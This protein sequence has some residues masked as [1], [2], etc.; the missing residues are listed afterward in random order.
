MP[1]AFPS[2][3]HSSAKASP[4]EPYRYVILLVGFVTL[5]GANGVS[6]SCQVFYAALL[7]VFDWSHAGGA[8]PYAVNQGKLGREYCLTSRSRISIVALN[9]GHGSG[10]CATNT[11]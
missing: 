10:T 4:S 7:A 8:S 5:A 1:A 6:S 3:A 11:G 9:G 2:D